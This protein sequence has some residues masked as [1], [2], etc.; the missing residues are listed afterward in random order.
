MYTLTRILTFILF[1]YIGRKY[2]NYKFLQRMKQV[3][4]FTVNP[5][6]LFIK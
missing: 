1:F 2:S 5:Y 3:N 4:T 6:K